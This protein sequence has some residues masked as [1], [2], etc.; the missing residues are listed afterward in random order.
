MTDKEITESVQ[1]DKDE[2]L[3]KEGKHEQI[4]VAH[5]PRISEV[6]DNNIHNIMKWLE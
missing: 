3:E 2:S 1:N 4:S 5:T 6:L